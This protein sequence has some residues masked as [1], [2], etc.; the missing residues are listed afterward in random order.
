LRPTKD[1]ESSTHLAGNELEV[2]GALGVTVTC[3][4]R[5]SS[6]VGRVLGKTTIGVHLDKV[7]GTVDTAAWKMG[8]LAIFRCSPHPGYLPRPE[9]STSKVNS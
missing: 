2:S 8:Q 3:T 4:V 9:T 1:E 6:L 5:S 7:Q